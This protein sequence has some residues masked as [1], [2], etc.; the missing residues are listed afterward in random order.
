M[1][2]FTVETT[3]ARSASDASFVSALTAARSEMSSGAPVRS[4]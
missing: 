2:A 1:T 4:A 3:V